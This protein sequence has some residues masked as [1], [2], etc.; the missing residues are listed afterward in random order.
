MDRLESER[1]PFFLNTYKAKLFLKKIPGVD[2]RA[3]AQVHECVALQTSVRV[4]Y[5]IRGS[6]LSVRN[7]EE[8]FGVVVDA[9]V[10]VQTLHARDGNDA[11]RRPVRERLSLEHSG[12]EG[13]V[14]MF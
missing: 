5:A 7:P 13:N 14:S 12:G 6:R 2:V 4:I 1:S 9:Y 11:D 10:V 8:E 3:Y